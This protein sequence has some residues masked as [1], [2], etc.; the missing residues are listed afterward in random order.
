MSIYSLGPSIGVDYKDHKHDLTNIDDNIKSVIFQ[1][2]CA[3]C[4]LLGSFY[5]LRHR[6]NEMQ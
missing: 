4:A 3:A 2:F 1:M 5:L 6:R